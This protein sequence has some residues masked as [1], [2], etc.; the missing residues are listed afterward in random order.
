MFGLVNSL[1]L[2]VDRTFRRKNPCYHVFFSLGTGRSV[3]GDLIV[4]PFRRSGLE[5]VPVGPPVCTGVSRTESKPDVVQFIYPWLQ[6]F[7]FFT[8]ENM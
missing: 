1:N 3:S 6:I 4:E 7:G 5:R 8:L 2:W